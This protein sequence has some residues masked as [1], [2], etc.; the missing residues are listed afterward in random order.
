MRDGRFWPLVLGVV[1][2]AL[3]VAIPYVGWLI[4]AVFILLSLGAL[5]I[6]AANW[7]RSRQAVQVM[8][9]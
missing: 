4:N 2:L 7:L 3:L 9:E 8:Q 5:W 6:V 1:I